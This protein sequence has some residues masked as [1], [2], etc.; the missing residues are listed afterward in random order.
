MKSINTLSIVVF[1]GIIIIIIG[2]IGCNLANNDSRNSTSLGID[3]NDVTNTTYSKEN[4][5][6]LYQQGT[7]AGIEVI[8]DFTQYHKVG[9]P[10]GTWYVTAT[11]QD[12]A[13]CA[14]V[15]VMAAFTI[16]AT[17]TGRA[18]LPDWF[19]DTVFAEAY[20]RYQATQ[21]DDLW[22]FQPG[23][24]LNVY[25]NDATYSY[26]EINAPHLNTR[27]FGG[28]LA[29]LVTQVGL[30]WWWPG[31]PGRA[32]LSGTAVRVELGN[33]IASHA[34]TTVSTGPA[35]FVL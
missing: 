12:R 20:T 16:D 33:P 34:A 27:S 24:V 5:Q 10:Y 22:Q 21:S 6:F 7:M 4:K 31:W 11:W 8:A 25:A 13:R 28:S 3:L 2:V 23:L 9:Q 1:V 17:G 26:Y 29:D 32:P 19:L 35:K 30:G 15:E 18:Q 14:I